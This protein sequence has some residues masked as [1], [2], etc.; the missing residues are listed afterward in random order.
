MR[1]DCRL[2]CSRASNSGDNSRDAEFLVHA[3]GRCKTT[4]STKRNFQPKLKGRSPFRPSS[5]LSTAAAKDGTGFPRG[6]WLRWIQCLTTVWTDGLVAFDASV[7]GFFT[8]PNSYFRLI[9]SSPIRRS[10]RL[11]TRRWGGYILNFGQG[12]NG[13]RWSLHCDPDQ[14]AESQYVTHTAWAPSTRSKIGSQE[15]PETG[16]HVGKKK[17]KPF[18]RPDSALLLWF[19]IVHGASFR[20]SSAIFVLLLRDH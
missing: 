11:I 12:P 13:S 4:T 2:M 15:R 18:E 19:P 7:H 17:V 8:N 10:L 20:R 14:A 9:K 6:R 3:V 1:R 16:L 5:S